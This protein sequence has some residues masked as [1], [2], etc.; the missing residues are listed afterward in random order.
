MLSICNSS[1][2]L[3][4]A[5]SGVKRVESGQIPPDIYLLDNYPHAKYSWTYTHHPKI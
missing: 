4:S 2:V 5:G 3:Y 1:G